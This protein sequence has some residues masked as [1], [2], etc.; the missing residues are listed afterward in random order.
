MAEIFWHNLEL[1]EV[2]KLLRTDIEMGLVEKEVAIRQRE[3]G[4]NKLPKEK[5][6]SKLSIFLVQFKSILIFI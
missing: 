4:K 3:F 6:P 5:P 2:E 1:K